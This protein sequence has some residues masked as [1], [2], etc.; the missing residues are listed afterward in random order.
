MCLEMYLMNYHTYNNSLMHLNE[1]INATKIMNYCPF[2]S[3]NVKKIEQ[4]WLIL[5]YITSGI[6]YFL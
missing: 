3:A 6:I 4:N 1:H 5:D 2:D